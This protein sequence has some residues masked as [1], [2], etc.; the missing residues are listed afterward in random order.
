ML[1]L[2]ETRCHFRYL[3]SQ[4]NLQNG[5][6]SC[7]GSQQ[8]KVPTSQD[9]CRCR[10]GGGGGGG[11][12]VQ[13]RKLFRYNR[14][15]GTVCVTQAMGLVSISEISNRRKLLSKIYSRMGQKCEI[16]VAHPFPALEQVG[17]CPP[18]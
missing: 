10:E 16:E 15:T 13:R 17:P 11:R 14:Y 8:S 18:G 9:T 3:S 2:H 7:L 1:A 6:R 5:L 4:K 12:G